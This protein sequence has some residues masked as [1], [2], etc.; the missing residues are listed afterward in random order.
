LLR[1][2]PRLRSKARRLWQISGTV[3]SPVSFP[4]GCRFHP[5]CPDAQPICRALVPPLVAVGDAHETAC[6]KH[7]GFQP[8]GN[9]A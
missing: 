5:R 1:A 4:P 7:A 3:P 9:A 6:W 8:V 2:V